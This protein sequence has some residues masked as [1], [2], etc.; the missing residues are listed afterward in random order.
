ML[1]FKVARN[2]QG[3]KNDVKVRVGTALSATRR[4]Q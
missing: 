4:H 2:Q 1:S 3:K